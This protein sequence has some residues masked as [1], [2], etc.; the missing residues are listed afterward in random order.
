MEPG[1]QSIEIIFIVAKYI[2][3]RINFTWQFTTNAWDF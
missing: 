1:K 3:Y 2:I